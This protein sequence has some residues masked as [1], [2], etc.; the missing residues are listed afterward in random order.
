MGVG[1]VVE[2]GGVKEGDAEW[3]KGVLNLREEWEWIVGV[4]RQDYI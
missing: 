3:G 2:W 1:G 4:N